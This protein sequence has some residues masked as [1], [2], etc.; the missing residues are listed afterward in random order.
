MRA[1]SHSLTGGTLTW[2]MMAGLKDWAAFAQLCS[3]RLGEQFQPSSSQGASSSSSFNQLLLVQ[4]TAD[5]HEAFRRLAS[6][7]LK[8][9]GAKAGV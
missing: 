7:L 1:C 6:M 4:P 5:R 3:K 9:D 8:E 2:L